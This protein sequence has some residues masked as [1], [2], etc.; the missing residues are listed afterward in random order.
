[1]AERPGEMRG[2][3]GTT[4]TDYRYRGDYSGR[5]Q[6][7]IR[8]DI[9]RTRAEMTE[10]VNEIEERLSPETLRDQAVSAVREAT[11]GRAE[12]MAQSAT[13]T[14]RGLSSDLMGTIRDNPIPSAL[15]GIGIGW[16]LLGRSSEREYEYEYRG[17]G[18][19]YD[20]S[21]QRMRPASG[22][23]ATAE[24][25]EDSAERLAKQAAEQAGDISSEAKQR[26]GEFGDEAREQ[27]EH[28]SMEA[29]R[30]VERAR[31]RLSQAVEDSPLTVAAAALA[32]GAAI[33]AAIPESR[34]EEELFGAANEQLMAKAR[35]AASDTADKVKHVAEE[36]RYA[37]AEAAKQEGLTT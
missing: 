37:A 11:I 30:G 25:V 14:V 5:D 17:R 27:I 3:T 28:V 10:T 26:V 2:A 32:V 4:A 13:R 24:R 6:E 33:G 7:R 34:T 35:E 19:P 16:L 21:G 29:R 12:D 36:A 1:M 20:E 31:S 9:E 23:R 18:Y 8:A 15:I 22:V